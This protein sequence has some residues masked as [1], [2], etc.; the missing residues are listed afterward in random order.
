MRIYCQAR[1]KKAHELPTPS[2]SNTLHQR[3]GLGHNLSKR[4]TVQPRGSDNPAKACY[5]AIIH[6]G[7]GWIRIVSNQPIQRMTC[8]IARDELARELPKKNGSMTAKT[9]RSRI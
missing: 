6:I 9:A 2:A 3:G 7:C 1:Q 5:D 4:Q 8:E